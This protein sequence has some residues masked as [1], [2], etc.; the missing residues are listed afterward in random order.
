VVIAIERSDDNFM[1]ADDL[2]IEP[3]NNE[4]EMQDLYNILIVDDEI[5]VHEVTKMALR[6]YL[7]NDIGL[8]ILSA[9]SGEGAIEL[10]EQRNDIAIILLD[11]VMETDDAGLKVANWIR[12][13]K[14]DHRVRIVLRTGQPGEAPEERIMV[15]YD[16]ND[17]KEKTELTNRK[18]NTLM[19]S[20]LRSYNDIIT[21]EATCHKLTE[22]VRNDKDAYHLRPVEVYS[23]GVIKLLMDLM[24]HSQSYL[25][26]SY[27]K[28][29]FEQALITSASGRYST[30][31]GSKL[32]SVIDI[33][34]FTPLIKGHENG[35]IEDNN[36]F[37]GH[38]VNDGVNYL[39]VLDEIAYVKKPED[40]VHIIEVFMHHIAQCYKK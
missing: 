40:D 36:Q 20:C 12:N 14:R 33:V 15:E 23:N 10:L 25:C 22:I 8:N 19:H 21:I 1:F 28:H 29:E 27:S 18:L 31:K 17:Y 2:N 3:D 37:L 39:I 11:V 6:N 38:V 9:Y 30:K 5:D 35:F 26:A 16:V 24:T 13:I 32:N 34:R 4:S 7:F